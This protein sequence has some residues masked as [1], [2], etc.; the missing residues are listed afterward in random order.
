MRPEGIIVSSTMIK[1]VVK[2]VEMAMFL[3]VFMG[4]TIS[5]KSE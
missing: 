5:K 4:Y 3:R 1:W 2:T